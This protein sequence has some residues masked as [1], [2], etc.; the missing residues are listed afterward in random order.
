MAFRR[1]GPD[2]GL[3]CRSSSSGSHSSSSSSRGGSGSGSIQR[4]RTFRIIALL[5][6]GANSNTVP[7]EY[8]CRMM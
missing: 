4:Y 1:L 6:L 3:S 2:I 8:V 7:R 5:D